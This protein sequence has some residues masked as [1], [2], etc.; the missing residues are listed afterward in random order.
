[1]LIASCACARALPGNVPER[2]ALQFGH[3]QFH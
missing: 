1:V 3:A 2:S